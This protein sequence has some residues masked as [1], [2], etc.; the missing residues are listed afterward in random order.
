MRTPTLD[1]QLGAALELLLADPRPV[2]SSAP[3]PASSPMPRTE[4]GV[5][6]TPTAS[7]TG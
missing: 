6:P 2:S 1:V 5:E 4:P 3:D 7:P